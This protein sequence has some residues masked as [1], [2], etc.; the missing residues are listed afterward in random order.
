MNIVFRTD[1]SLEIG[2]GHVMRYLT[3][4]EALRDRGENCRF[5]CREHPGNILGLI[6]FLLRE[7]M[8]TNLKKLFLKSVN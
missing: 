5:I 2:T 8:K 6:R 7:F 4:A 1:S 3:L